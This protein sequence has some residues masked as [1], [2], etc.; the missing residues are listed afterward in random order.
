MLSL[1][2]FLSR[3]KIEQDI[4]LNFNK[5]MPYG[6]KVKHIKITDCIGSLQGFIVLILSG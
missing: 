4:S 1:Y 5:W 2:K 6:T 3:T